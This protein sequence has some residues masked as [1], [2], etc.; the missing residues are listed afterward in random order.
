MG[1]LKQQ[2]HNLN[3]LT[4]VETA[5][6]FAETWQKG[7]LGGSAVECLPSAQAEILGS[8]DRAP[9]RASCMEPASLSLSLSH[10]YG[11]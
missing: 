5:T 10:E 3:K 7:H 1:A 2:Q 6:L 4:A 11:K 9:H 8:W